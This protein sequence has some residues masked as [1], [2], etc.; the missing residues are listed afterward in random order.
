MGIETDVTDTRAGAPAAAGTGVRRV[1]VLLATAL[2][3]DGR[4]AAAQPWEGATVLRRLLDQLAG[5]G[6]E[7]VS[8]IARP[9]SE[10]ALRPS[11]GDARLI[12][13]IA[14]SEDPSAV[15]GVA[16]GDDLLVAY[17]DIVIH[18]SALA[19]LLAG[20]TAALVDAGTFLG[21]L[22]VAAADRAGLS[23]AAQQLGPI[24]GAPDDDAAAMLVAGLVHSGVVVGERPLR[25]FF[26]ARPL[27]GAELGR[28]ARE[29]ESRD[30]E[31]A[32]LDSAVKANDGFF[33]TFFVS[34]YSKYVA[35][36]AAR[37]RLT[38]NQVTVA[39][40]AVGLAAA[41]A[42]AT[43]DR[44]GLI[45]GAVLVQVAFMLDCVDGQLARYTGTFSSFGAWLDS[46]LDRAKEYA[47][48][49]GLAIGAAASGHPVWLLAGAALTLQTVRQ[50]FDLVFVASEGAGNAVSGAAGRA[51]AFSRG[52]DATRGVT[53]V[54]RVLV[55]PIGERLAAI[56]LTAALFTP[57]TTFFVLLAYGGFALLYLLAGR[58]MR[59]LR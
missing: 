58:L 53:W 35:R 26:W 40:M 45:L 4:P 52:L 30:E 34:P 9:G 12:T 6:V 32:R 55:F 47:V 38:P 15:A 29:L 8:V 1:A 20:P 43:G 24:T 46:I 16:S 13:S 19:G 57:R 18:G 2:A 14:A 42:F 23:S 7:E 33:T 21:A 51:L 22:K 17:A 11:L 50:T 25:R 49:A 48:Y 59:S 28:A 44:L 41:A 36:W 37:R 31:R 54:K 39:S 5:L 3:D 56:S 10:A 27:S